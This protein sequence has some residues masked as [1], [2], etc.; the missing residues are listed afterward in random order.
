M[1][2]RVGRPRSLRTSARRVAAGSAVAAVLLPVAGC[3][4]L[5]PDVQPTG[6]TTGDRTPPEGTTGLEPFYEQTL[7]WGAC[8]QGAGE[9]AQ[10][11]VPVDYDDPDGQTIEIAVLRV[12]SKKDAAGSLV[13]NPG[14]PGGSGVEYAA[15]ADVIVSGQIRNHFDVVGFDPR[16]VGR[17]APV[18]CLD[19]ADLDDYLAKDPTPDTDEERAEDVQDKTDLAEGCV[20][21]SGEVIEHVS[22]ADAA[23]DMDV[24]RAALGDGKLTYLGK[25]YGTYLGTTYAELFPDRVGR[26]VLDGVIPPDLTGE[27][28]AIGQAKGFDTATK[29]WAQDCVDDSCPL[30]DGV[31]D[32]VRSMQEQLEELDQ[33]PLPA[34]AGI[35]LTEG[36]ATWGIAQA[37]YDQGMWSQLTDA[38]V[39]ARDGDGGPLSE[40]GRAYAGRDADGGYASNLLEALPA[41][42]CLDRPEKGSD[43]EALA[44]RAS[45]VAPIW[46]R[47]LAY[48]SPCPQWAVDSDHVPHEVE[49]KGADPILVVG[50]TRDPATP[51]EWA[52]RLH[53]QLA[54]SALVTHEG[55]GHTAY[56]RQNDCVDKAVDRYWLTG[57]LPEGGELTC[58]E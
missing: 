10:L 45:K 36:W 51:Y 48:E 54:D 17:S 1:R 14:G 53:D 37:M 56:M 19:D 41:V 16:G 47:A 2:S 4:L 40:L 46:G 57:E 13:V 39:S 11:E 25:S 15:A 24:L 26:L 49:A 50:T 33:Q 3:S 55:D 30:G 8:E 18:D 29:A 27:E 5:E 32:V 20:A 7:E 38:L 21:K 31:D 35:E 52:Q 28:V 12:P 42:N 43:P 6:L 23:R 58:E 9:C 22:T 44:A 34:T